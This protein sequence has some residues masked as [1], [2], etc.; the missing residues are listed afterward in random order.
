MLFHKRKSYT[1]TQ[2][3]FYQIYLNDINIY[4]YQQK[5]PAPH[6]TK[7]IYNFMTSND[8]VF[9]NITISSLPPKTKKPKITELHHFHPYPVLGY[10]RHVFYAFNLR[11]TRLPNLF[12]PVNKSMF[13][14]TCWGEEKTKNWEELRTFV[15]NNTI[16]SDTNRK[17]VY[18]FSR[19]STPTRHGRANVFVTK[20]HDLI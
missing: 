5:K 3:H 7:Y 19:G 16:W 17:M 8:F 2:N 1:S 4:R 11:R 14:K 13:N 9:V 20:M 12:R 6:N 15:L 10:F 18:R